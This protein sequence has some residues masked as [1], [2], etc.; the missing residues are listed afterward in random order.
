ML[1]VAAYSV[2]YLF[3]NVWVCVCYIRVASDVRIDDVRIDDVRIDDVRIDDV[4]NN[5]S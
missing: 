5:V 2:A 1:L 4:H 3:S